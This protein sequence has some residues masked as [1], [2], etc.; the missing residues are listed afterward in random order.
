MNLPVQGLAA[1]ILKLALGRIII[2]LPSRPWLR[3]LLQ[4]H[5]EL[6]FEVPEDKVAEAVAFIKLCMEAQ[7]FDG[8]DV[9]I[10]AEA[11][12]GRRF[13]AMKELHEYANTIQ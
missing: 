7:P 8:F 9:P 2:G 1:D 6:A 10:V 4:I 5:D 3:P 13:G 12:V 11:S